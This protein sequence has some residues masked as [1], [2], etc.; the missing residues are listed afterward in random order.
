MAYNTL[1]F[2]EFVDNVERTVLEQIKN[3][4]PN[5]VRSL[6]TSVPW[7]EGDSEKVTFNSVCLSGFAK[8]VT[9]NEDYE[10]VN[11]KKGNE[12]TKTQIQYGDKLE[13]T[14]SMMKFN[15]RYAEAKMVTSATSLVSRLRDTLDNE[16][17]MQALAEADQTTV[18]FPGGAGTNIATSD[19]QAVA[20]ASHNY[21]GVTFSN[22]LSGGPALS[23]GNMNA[24][25]NQG[26]N[27]TP[28]DFGTFY[29]PNFD[30]IVIGPDMDMVV[31]CHELFGS[32]LTPS[33]GNNAV[34]YFNG[35]GTMKVVQ[36]KFGNRL[37]TGA[38]DTSNANQY[39]WMLMDSTMCRESWQF[40]MAEEPTP[41]QKFTDSDNLLA[42]ILVTQ[43]ASFAIV[44]P[45]GT[46]YS[47]STTKPTLG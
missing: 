24:A 40:M 29:A 2:N 27:G 13:I 35:P 4:Q 5:L 30:T 41:E 45:Q 11:P 42:K 46:I 31:M 34:N 1:A 18:N 10:V 7:N 19:A 47:L 28:D 39:R 26:I 22:I 12:L 17:T 6:F 3:I 33:T 43:F 36:L 9:E 16:M 15:T 37:P 32:S 20:S 25:L 21:G 8:R 14:R 44:Q 23:K 38:V